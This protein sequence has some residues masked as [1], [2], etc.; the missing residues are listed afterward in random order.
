MAGIDEKPFSPSEESTCF[1]ARTSCWDPFIIFLVDLKN[2][3]HSASAEHHG[4]PPPPGYPRP[5][6]NALPVAP[7]AGPVPI[8]YN[9]PIVLQCLSTAVVSPVMVI[10]KVDKGS[11]ATGGA[12][13]DGHGSGAAMSR[14]LPVAPGEIIGDPVSQLHK[15]ALEVMSDP[16]GVYANANQNAPGSPFPGAGSFLACLGKSELQTYWVGVSDLLT[17]VF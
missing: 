5:P 10:R 3:P 1:V 2:S 16:E 14:D 7:G 15:I 13:L 12:S 17:L 9:Q 11:T 6:A 4:P 8:Y